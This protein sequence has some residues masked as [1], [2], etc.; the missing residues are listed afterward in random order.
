MPERITRRVSGLPRGNKPLTIRVTAVDS[1][2]NRSE[3]L[4]MDF[5]EK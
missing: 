2:G 3:P 4:S 1:Y 5:F